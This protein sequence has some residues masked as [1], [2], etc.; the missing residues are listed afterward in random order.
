MHKV[1]A[2]PE[3]VHFGFYSA[4]LKPILT[5]R[6]GEEVEIDTSRG[7]RV[8]GVAEPMY[9][10]MAA[11]ADKKE[12]EGFMG[13]HTLT[14]PIGVEGAEPGD[15]L[16]LRIK[17]IRLRTEFA[18]N[19]HGSHGILSKYFPNTFSKNF[20]C[21]EPEK[22]VAKNVFPGIS[23]PLHP[24]FGNLG[25]APPAKLGRVNSMVPGSHCGNLDIKELV[26][27]VTVY[28]PILAKGG[29]FSCGDGH[30]CQADGEADGT[31]METPL[32]GVFQFILRKD[33]SLKR[34]CAET[35]THFMTIAYHKNLKTAAQLVVRDMVSFLSKTWKLT[36]DEAYSLVSLVGEM[37]VSQLV[38]VIP[39]IHFMVPKAIFANPV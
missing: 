34:P 9:S 28:L 2:I 33:L 8:E 18:V 17:E 31:A 4:D 32:T 7:E 29:L 25:I 14:G 11:L 21:L 1:K 23:L 36:E 38:N 19:K 24:F 10:E 30:A 16:E 20:F 3:N 37:H 22:N 39:G 12:R 13:P 15:A 5:V 6:S 26:P 27:G 35:P